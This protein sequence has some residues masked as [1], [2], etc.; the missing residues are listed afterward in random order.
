MSK[1]GLF[2]KSQ[3][4]GSSQISVVEIPSITQAE[5]YFA[6]RKQLTLEQFRELFIVKE[7]DNSQKSLM[8]GNR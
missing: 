7:I 5:S 8:Y 3:S 2:S 6:G 1:Y 4:E